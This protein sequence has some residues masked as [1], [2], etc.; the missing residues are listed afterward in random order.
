MKS[1]SLYNWILDKG[2]FMA[3]QDRGWGISTSMNFPFPQ[4][5]VIY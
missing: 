2:L 5:M 4:N 3:N 1:V